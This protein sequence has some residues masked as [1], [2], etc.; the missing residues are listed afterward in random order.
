LRIIA[1]AAEAAGFDSVWASDHIVHPLTGEAPYPYGSGELPFRAEDGYLEALTT[2]AFVAGCTE[3]IRLGTSVLV[4]P[5][6]EVL[7]TGKVLASLDALS[8]GR[9]AVTVATGWW[10]AEYEA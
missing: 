3:R 9:V 4:L 6:R 2:L 8:G 1:Q 5:M 10:Q 7:L